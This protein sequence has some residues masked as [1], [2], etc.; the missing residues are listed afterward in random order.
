[1]KIWFALVVLVVTSSRVEADV[2][3]ATA[4]LHAC[5]PTS[6]KVAMIAKL[7][8]DL[9]R[10]AKDGGPVPGADQEMKNAQLAYASVCAS[11]ALKRLAGHS[12]PRAYLAKQLP[13]DVCNLLEPQGFAEDSEGRDAAAACTA[14]Q[15]TALFNP[16]GI[17]INVVTGLGD[18]LEL[19]AKE[20]IAQYLIEQIGLRFCNYSFTFR[21][22][23]QQTPK[24]TTTIQLSTWFPSSCALIRKDA[25]D[26][27][28][29]GDLKKAFLA[30]VHA[31]PT[32]LAGL[33]N[34]V[35]AS[36]S[37]GQKAWITIAAIL[38]DVAFSVADNKKPLEILQDLGAKADAQTSDVTC[39]F[40]A[41]TD[42]NRKEC[43][44]LLLFQLARTAAA[45]YH[46]SG[47]P[48]LTVVITHAL[49][50]FCKVHGT[51][52]QS[53]V[54][55]VIAAPDY[56]AWHQRLLDFYRAAKQFLDLH[57]NVLRLTL[58]AS[59]SE[60]AARSAGDLAKALKQLVASFAEILENL[61][62]LKSDT[63]LA[64]ELTFLQ[65]TLDIY[66]AIIADDPVAFRQAVVVVLKSKLLAKAIPA[67]AARAVT[68][69][70]SLATA[71][72]HTEAKSILQEVADPVGTYKAKFGGDHVMIALNGN[73]GFMGA[74]QVL[75]GRHDETG[76]GIEHKWRAAPF[77]ISAPV[78]VDFT[79]W[80]WPKWHAGFTVT[81][82][83][84]LALE[85]HDDNG[86]LSA[87]WPSL[88]DFGAY[89]RLGV[90][91][92]PFTL[93][94]GAHGQP[95][96]R[97]DDMCGASRCYAGTFSVGFFL[98]ADVPLHMFR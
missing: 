6:G 91:R 53:D 46:G 97:S 68:V 87:Y 92:S 49:E 54:E 69:I 98:T 26:T 14:A 32:Q 96:S 29:F 63:Q 66:A 38:A 76:A 88:F 81:V 37:G 93:M 45:E 7:T 90:W 27:F 3:L 39:D 18:L 4:M 79:W 41:K 94:L 85:V 57:D 89:A 42:P 15:E 48:A 51:A 60:I 50:A 23:G 65:E 71:K 5:R 2:D 95:W 24:L 70:V 36:L 12:Y 75:F 55:C 61:P 10:P 28:T 1:M 44:A 59:D 80:S 21:L 62:E 30:D 19:E 47:Q 8:V 78:G 9:A 35:F 84:P 64:A 11:P 72:D 73:V 31:L 25:P 74:G 20:E 77:R 33:A 22:P 40:S 83:D 17:A 52:H 13:V 34:A 82:I 86:S 67:E 58:T 56:E 43:A 16:A